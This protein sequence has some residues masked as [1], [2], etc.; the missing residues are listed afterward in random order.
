LQE[1]VPPGDGIHS[2]RLP[3]A[4]V[5]KHLKLPDVHFAKYFDSDSCSVELKIND[6]EGYEAIKMLALA[7]PINAFSMPSRSLYEHTTRHVRGGQKMGAVVRDARAQERAA[8][9]SLEEMATKNAQMQEERAESSLL[10]LRAFLWF[11]WPCPA[12]S[13]HSA[14]AGFPQAWSV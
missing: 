12:R 4:A 14:H 2:L 7:A 13:V 5:V 9:R 6:C 3:P 1:F 8:F 11:L 10:T